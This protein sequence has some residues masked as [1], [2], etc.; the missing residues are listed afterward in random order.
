MGRRRDTGEGRAR[1]AARGGPLRPR[2][3]PGLHVRGD[4]RGAGRA[5]RHRFLSAAPRGFP[6]SSRTVVGCAQLCPPRR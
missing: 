4:D 3:P 1:R 2:R 6:G 5:R